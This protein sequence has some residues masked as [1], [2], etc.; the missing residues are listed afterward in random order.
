VKRLV[1]AAILV[2]LTALASACGGDGRTLRAP[3]ADQDLSIVTTTTATPSLDNAP[4][5]QPANDSASPGFTAEWQQGGAM[6][7][8]TTCKGGAQSPAL[9]WSNVPP[10]V[11]EIAVSAIDLDA[12]NAVHWIMAGISPSASGLA[13]GLVP[14]GAVRTRNALGSSG[15]AAPCPTSGTHRI[16]FTLYFLV[17]RSGLLET[18]DATTAINT[19]DLASGQRATLV[20]T[21]TA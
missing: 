18:M 2:A 9:T 17:N 1:P 12:Q 14:P 16:L 4:G 3:N 10:D 7:I 15:Y 11:T 6:P 21:V 19:L 20:G 8:D 13:R 5:E